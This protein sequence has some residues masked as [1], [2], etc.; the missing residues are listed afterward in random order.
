MPALSQVT[1][2]GKAVF[3]NSSTRTGLWLKSEGVL[4]EDNVVVIGD[5]LKDA[6][7]SRSTMS[8]VD[9]SGE[10]ILSLGLQRESLVVEKIKLVHGESVFS[11]DGVSWHFAARGMN[12]SLPVAVHPVTIG[13][14]P[15]RGSRTEIILDHPKCGIMAQC[16]DVGQRRVLKSFSLA[17]KRPV[18]RLM[19]A[20]S[21][22][23]SS[24]QLDVRFK[25]FLQ[26]DWFLMQG[27]EFQMG[28]LICNDKEQISVDVIDDDPQVYKQVCEM[29]MLSGCRVDRRDADHR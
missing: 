19:K 18:F 15:P 10:T 13:E 11:M 27:E 25:Q 14:K 28:Y 26:K 7:L 21:N 8:I 23:D 29:M 16:T 3:G 4:I 2:S 1:A 24:L 6:K 5:N 9:K 17:R 20:S 12:W 22:V